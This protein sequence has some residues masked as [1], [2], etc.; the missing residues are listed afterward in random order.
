MT[1]VEKL[2]RLS[3]SENSTV[4]NISA[5]TIVH[6]AESQRQH[7][8]VQLPAILAIRSKRGSVHRLE[9]NDI[10]ATGIAFDISENLKI[11]DS[12]KGKL[13]FP[14]T[15]FSISLDVSLNVVD[16]ESTTVRAMFSDLPADKIAILRQVISAYIAGEIV[17]ANELIHVVSRDNFVK[18]RTK[19][20]KNDEGLFKTFLGTGLYLAAG[21]L[22]LLYLIASLYK[23]T[24]VSNSIAANVTGDT[25]Q[26]TMPR[27]GI[28]QSFVTSSDVTLGQTIGKHSWVKYDDSGVESE[29][30][31]LIVSPCDC[32][33]KERPAGDGAL[34]GQ[35]QPLFV[36]VPKESDLF[37][38]S[39]FNYQKASH[40]NLG[41]RVLFE[42]AGS[43]KMPGSIVNI[44]ARDDHVFVK[45]VP[46]SPLNP[47]QF[48]LPVKVKVDR[49]DR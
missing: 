44:D 47:D 2:K 14:F 29:E 39:R 1:P 5:R 36:L 27:G 10:S 40:F 16:R 8:R 38:E 42:I 33:I 24:L 21:L 15:A 28:F 3:N 20:E 4:T 30:S 45:V 32:T 41:D 11:N 25:L 49:W 19:T 46:E 9:V 13:I 43:K 18:P 37:I 48:G 34:V 6:E 35:G 26:I 22:A 12:F 31:G 23:L 7:V 17:S